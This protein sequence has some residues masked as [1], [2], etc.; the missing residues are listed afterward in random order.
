M[1]RPQL[2][3]K[4][5]ALRDQVRV[6]EAHSPGSR[7]V[8]VVVRRADGGAGGGR[9]L[10]PHPHPRSGHGHAGNHAANAA[11]GSTVRH[12]NS[13]RRIYIYSNNEEPGRVHAPDERDGPASGAVRSRHGAV[14]NTA[15]GSRAV[16]YIGR[17]CAHQYHRRTARLSIV[18]VISVAVF[19]QNM[20]RVMACRCSS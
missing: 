5:G 10:A 16:C 9:G 13:E 6:G 12:Q 2:T 17:L 18:I 15:D 7:S 14:H 1:K 4:H 11:A 3:N 19:A 8:V 20:P